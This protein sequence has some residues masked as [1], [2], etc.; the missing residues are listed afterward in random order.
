MGITSSIIY[1]DVNM[2]LYFVILCRKAIPCAETAPRICNVVIKAG[3]CSRRALSLPPCI[4]L[5]GLAP[6]IKKLFVLIQ[7]TGNF[8]LDYELYL[9]MKIA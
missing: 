1:S 2:D 9:T 4:T 5:P 3:E 8:I 6:G 7:R